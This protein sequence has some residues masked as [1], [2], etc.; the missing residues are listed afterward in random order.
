MIFT[1]IL[2]FTVEDIIDLAQEITAWVIVFCMKTLKPVT[3]LLN[4]T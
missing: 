3:W 4:G 1:F 2:E